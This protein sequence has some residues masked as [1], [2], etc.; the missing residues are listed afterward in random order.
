MRGSTK[1]VGST[2]KHSTIDN[3]AVKQTFTDEEIESIKKYM[4]SNSES[5]RVQ[6][7]RLPKKYSS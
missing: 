3:V 7:K 2:N 4:Q 6:Y 5:S 1:S